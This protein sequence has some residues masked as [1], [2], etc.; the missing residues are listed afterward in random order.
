M[1]MPDTS[2]DP[3]LGPLESD[4][5]DLD[6]TTQ[7]PGQSPE[8]TAW[9]TEN[10]GHPTG[11][12]VRGRQSRDK[13]VISR[14]GVVTPAK[15]V[16][17]IRASLFDVG[18]GIIVATVANTLT[19]NTL[20]IE[21]KLGKDD[22][23]LA[24]VPS[25]ITMASDEKITFKN[26]VGVAT[27]ALVA[28]WLWSRHPWPSR[29]GRD[30]G[31]H[32]VLVTASGG[33]TTAFLTDLTIVLTVRTV[34]SGVRVAPGVAVVTWSR[35]LGASQHGR[36]RAGPTGRVLGVVGLKPRLPPFPPL[37]LSLLLLPSSSSLELPCDS[38]TVLGAL[39]ALG[40]RVEVVSPRSCRG[41]AHGT[42]SEEEVAIPT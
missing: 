31:G 39:G 24:F 7:V 33:I 37:S 32:H 27:G 19:S 42:W 38:L 36:C 1:P 15:L 20:S 28:T 5:T 35:R 34:V 40:D 29:H 13:L 17:G 14:E 2:G 22:G 12:L 8:L 4:D 25:K 21:V 18:A 16:M 3:G 30:G 23:S 41:R 11:E 9:L 10:L 6:G 26:N